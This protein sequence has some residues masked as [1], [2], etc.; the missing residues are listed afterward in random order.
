MTQRRPCPIVNLEIAFALFTLSA[1]AA[2]AVAAPSI[3]WFTVDG[4]GGTSSGAIAGGT[5]SIHGTA[6]QFD[7]GASTFA[8][9]GVLGGYW[10][11][12]PIPSG[13][14]S[15]LDDGS[16]LGHPDGAVT[17][18]DLLYFLVGFEAGDVRVDLDDGSGT[19]ARDGAVTVD[20]L[21][22]FLVHFE[23]GC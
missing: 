6:G 19:G 1:F 8:G 11:G 12:G 10:P 9:I 23:G 14:P 15:D 21:L 22:F 5:I 7:A 13:C 17:I 16:M 3:P 20:D 2:M 4:G 18:D